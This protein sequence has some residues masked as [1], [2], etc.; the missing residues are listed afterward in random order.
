MRE[1]KH[2]YDAEFAG[3]LTP[4]LEGAPHSRAHARLSPPP[5]QQTKERGEPSSAKP[6]LPQGPSRP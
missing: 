2:R 3:A 4:E 1:Q 5:A 6:D